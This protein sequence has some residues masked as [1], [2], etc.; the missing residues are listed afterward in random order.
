MYKKNG[1]YYINIRHNGRRYQESLKTGDRKKAV[2]EEAHIK[3]Q[4]FKDAFSKKDVIQET[5]VHQLMERFI[6][7]HAPTVSDNMQTSYG[8]YLKHIL[9]FFGKFLLTEVTRKHITKY[10]SFRTEQGAKPSTINRE[11]GVISKAYSLAVEDWELLSGND[12]P[13]GKMPYLPENNERT[14]WLKPEQEIALLECSPIWLSEL[15]LFAVN[16]GLRKG[17]LLDL[18]WDRVNLIA[19]TIYIEN[20]KSGNPRTLPL[21]KIALDL[22]KA[23]DKNR[24]NV[25]NFRNNYV[26]L[27]NANTKLLGDNVRRAFLSAVT[28]AGIEDFTFH[29][30]RHTYASRLAQAGVDLYKISKLLGHKDI[31]MTQRYSHICTDSLRGAVEILES[32]HS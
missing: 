29:D 32:V 19:K 31:R 11:L 15:I 7:E 10:K 23:K 27:S 25:V 28:K 8:C 30:L 24:N 1:I 18:Q 14:R 5:I 3:D 9:P 20:T 13:F 16:T 12:K 26:F 17:E 21:N 2:A 22:L 6:K 4:I